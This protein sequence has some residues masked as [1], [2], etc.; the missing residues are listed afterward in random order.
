[1]TGTALL[2]V[3]QP[4]VE[5]FEVWLR[6]RTANRAVIVDSARTAEYVL[7]TDLTYEDLRFW[8]PTD[9]FDIQDASANQM[10]DAANWLLHARRRFEG[11]RSMED[12]ELMT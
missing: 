4:Y 9:A 5:T 11:T 1:M 3:E 7:G 12:Q 8:L 6:L 2:M 10:T